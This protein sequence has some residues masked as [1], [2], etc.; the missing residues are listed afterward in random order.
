LT[1]DECVE[2]FNDRIAKRLK[3]SMSTLFE[4]YYRQKNDSVIVQQTSTPT[5]QFYYTYGFINNGAL[6]IVSQTHVSSGKLAA[7]YYNNN[8]K[9][10]TAL[11]TLANLDT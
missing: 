6:I 7:K 3:K 4:G 2:V 1:A 9:Q 8:I 10:F 11:Y 5:R